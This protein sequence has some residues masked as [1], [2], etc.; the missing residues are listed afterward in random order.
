[1]AY[2]AIAEWKKY[3]HYKDRNP[4]WIK[5]HRDLLTS[6]TWVLLD[7]ASRVLA[8]ACMMIAAATDN[9]IPCDCDYVRRV[10]Y[11]NSMPDFIPL[12]ECGFIEIQEESTSKVNNASNP[13][14]LPHDARPEAEAEAEV[15]VEKNTTLLSRTDFQKVF[16]F[17]Y[18]I[19]PNLMTAN[20]SEIH[21]WLQAG[22]SIEHDI[23]PSIKRCEG[24]NVKSWN[25]F[26][27]AVMDAKA[28][29]E[30]PLPKGTA[31]ET[32]RST[33]SS[34][35][36]ASE[37]ERLAAKYAAEAERERQAA[38]LIHAEPSLRIAESLR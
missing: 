29:R 2:Y 35:S 18:G 27:G 13:Y 28:T 25:Y 32:T 33:K 9:K 8:I 11:L 12:I 3:Q 22:C 26:S 30:K 37:A 34:T 14:Q 6:R 36:F 38:A 19:F 15:E 4:P 5:L 31:H 24:K 7:D 21:K 23:L 1:M 16:E 17:G 20:T 10:A